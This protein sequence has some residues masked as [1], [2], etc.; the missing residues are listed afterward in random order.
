MR[1]IATATLQ[2]VAKPLIP[3]AKEI[4]VVRPVKV[5]AAVE[6]AVSRG[7]YQS[8]PT[9]GRFSDLVGCRYYCTVVN[10]KRGCCPNG[11]NC[12]G[13]PPPKCTKPNYVLCP[14]ENFCCRGFTLTAMSW[15]ILLNVFRLQ[16]RDTNA[17]EA[18]TTPLHAALHLAHTPIIPS[19]SRPSAPLLR[20]SHFLL[21][22]LQSL[23]R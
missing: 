2:G 4:L 11:K 6:D 14:G 1:P 7:T 16:R 15:L 17:T 23:L 18:L 22:W 13:D 3:V 19:R 8:L 5:A 10:G 12:N 9:L 21:R 20:W